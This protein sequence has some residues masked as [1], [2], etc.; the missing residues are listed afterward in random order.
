[1]IHNSHLS[2][3]EL[4]THNL[5]TIALA[6]TSYYN[7]NSIITGNILQIRLPDRDKVIELP[8]NSNGVTILNSN[9]L[10]ITNIVDEQFLI[11]LPDGAYTAKI[12]ICPYDQFWFESTWYRI[13]QLQ[14]KYYNAILKL[15]L[16][17]CQECFSPEVDN[18]IWT[19]KRFID[20][21]KA[22][23]EQGNINQ[24]SKLY[25]VANYILDDILN[26]TCKGQNKSRGWGQG[27]RHSGNWNNN[28]PG[29]PYGFSLMA[30]TGKCGCN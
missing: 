24:A 8:Y 5:K 19:A 3:L 12:S 16:S 28:S 9:S 29:S 17:Q 14:C 18:E 11:D 23:V 1:M 21:I 10:G 4:P 6:D 22:N 13:D 2:F 15:D 26:C 20:G 30:P 27:K 7:P 25:N